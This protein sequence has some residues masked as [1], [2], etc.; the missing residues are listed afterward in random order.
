MDLFDEA[1]TQQRLL[2]RL[3]RV[4]STALTVIVGAA[5]LL[6]AKAAEAG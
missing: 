4:A 1:T 2:V 5:V 6:L 3:R